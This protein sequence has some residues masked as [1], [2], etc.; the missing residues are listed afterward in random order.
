[1]NEKSDND[2]SWIARLAPRFWAVRVVRHLHRRILHPHRPRSIVKRL[3]YLQTF[4]A[5]LIYLLVVAGIW[6][7]SNYL[8]NDSL[9]GRGKVWLGKLDELGT[10]IYT[11]RGRKTSQ[12]IQR[13]LTEFPELAYIRYIDASGHKVLATFQTPG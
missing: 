4:W 8:V 3:L 13:L 2:A 5:I 11:S 9:N 1:M 12:R 7:S 6:Y 10:P